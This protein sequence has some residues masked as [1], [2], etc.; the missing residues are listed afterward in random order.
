M[1]LIQQYLWFHQEVGSIHDID[2]P[3]GHVVGFS[4]RS[5]ANKTVNE[6]AVGIFVFDQQTTILAIADGMGGANSGDRAR[7][8]GDPIRC[9]PG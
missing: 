7:P 3:A 9:R 8:N 1:K 5:P 2:C 6:D 4:E